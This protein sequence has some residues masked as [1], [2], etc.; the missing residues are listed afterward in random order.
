MPGEKS[1]GLCFR[2]IGLRALRT[3]RLEHRRG[4]GRP[5]SAGH[6]RWGAPRHRVFS[7]AT[8]TSLWLAP[9]MK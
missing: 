4:N 8:Q 9:T 5:K 1:P 7:C 6:F 3:L 2:G